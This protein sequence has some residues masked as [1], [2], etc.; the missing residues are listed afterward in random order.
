MK[1]SRIWIWTCS[2]RVIF[3]ERIFVFN[4]RFEEREETSQKVQMH[5]GPGQVMVKGAPLSMIHV[6]K[7]K[8]SC[9]MRELV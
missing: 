8:N 7:G 2:P 1:T 4:G 3:V 6:G 5:D 9:E